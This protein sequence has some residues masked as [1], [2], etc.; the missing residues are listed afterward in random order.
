MTAP[1]ASPVPPIL[2]LAAGAGR[3]MRGTDKLLEPVGGVPLLRHIATQARA[4]GP[5]WVCL[6]PDA[7]QRRAVLVGLTCQIVPVPDADQGM[8]ASLRRGVAALPTDAP[9]VMLVLAD[10]PELSAADFQC[11]SNS[12]R[13]A[14]DQI[15]RAV[16]AQGQPGH[17]VV[18]PARLR[19]AL[20]EVSGD[21]GARDILRSERVITVPLPG[22]RATTDLDTPEA[23]AD[24]RAD[25]PNRSI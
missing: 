19:G 3:R 1:A 4:V 12:F 9:G 22:Q 13:T 20:G 24:W 25:Q 7:P 17:P 15:H 8:S 6:P 10:M 21:Q 2:I 14:P 23:W 5:L 11:M 18:F 16:N